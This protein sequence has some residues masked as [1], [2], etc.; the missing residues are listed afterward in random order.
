MITNCQGA[1]Q[2][3]QNYSSGL[4]QAPSLHHLRLGY[5][6][7]V[8]IWFGSGERKTT[9][10]KPF[11]HNDVRIVFF[12]RAFF[13]SSKFCF[14]NAE[15]KS[16]ESL[17]GEK[18]EEFMF[19]PVQPISSWIFHVI[20]SEDLRVRSSFVISVLAIK[21]GINAIHPEFPILF[22]IFIHQSVTDKHKMV[23]FEVNKREMSNDVIDWWLLKALASWFAP[24]PW[25]KL[26]AKH[27]TINPW[28]NIR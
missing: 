24:S 9:L 23:C 3:T 15:G 5:L 14:S 27:K 4:Q 2:S 1:P 26:P 21:I 17:R 25:M 12:I 6:F 18:R 11:N 13:N 19:I 7:I 28:W 10:N 8:V 16:P 22:P 20:T